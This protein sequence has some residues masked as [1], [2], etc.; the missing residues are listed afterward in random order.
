M[1]LYLTFCLVKFGTPSWKIQKMYSNKVA[2]NSPKSLGMVQTW[3]GVV[4]SPASFQAVR[5]KSQKY[6]GESLVMKKDSPST[7]S[8]LN[9]AI[10]PASS[11]S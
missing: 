11:R 2:I 10:C 5:V 7:F 3:L 1:Q 9:G 6:I 4:V 8:W